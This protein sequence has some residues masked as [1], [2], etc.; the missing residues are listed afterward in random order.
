MC[1]QQQRNIVNENIA[2]AHNL[3]LRFFVD[4]DNKS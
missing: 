1:Q 2:D 4:L 3:L